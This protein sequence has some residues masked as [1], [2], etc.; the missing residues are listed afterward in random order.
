MYWLVV[1]TAEECAG[2][3]AG[4]TACHGAESYRTKYPLKSP[5]QK[6]IIA[7]ATGYAR[8]LPT[9]P[10]PDSAAQA[11]LTR[12]IKPVFVVLEVSRFCRVCKF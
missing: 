9:D 10:Q 12:S 3:H 7:V 8:V 1:D 6:H 11:Y 5:C 4:H 2:F